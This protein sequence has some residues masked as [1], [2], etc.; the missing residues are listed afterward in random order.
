[1]FL[2]K[3]LWQRDLCWQLMILFLWIRSTVMLAVMGLSVIQWRFSAYLGK[4]ENYWIPKIFSLLLQELFPLLYYT[5]TVQMQGFHSLLYIPH[6][7]LENVLHTV[8]PKNP[9]MLWTQLKRLW[10][11]PMVQKEILYM[12]PSPKATSKHLQKGAPGGLSR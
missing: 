11:L 1:M 6:G 10:N 5:L 3:A 4:K 2:Q 8:V 9:D 12:E 7:T